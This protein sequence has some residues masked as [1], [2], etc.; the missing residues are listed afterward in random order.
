MHAT[1][2][3]HTAPGTAGSA[4]DYYWLIPKIIAPIF[5]SSPSFKM[6]RFSRRSAHS[7]VSTGKCAKYIFQY[8]QVC[9]LVQQVTLLLMF[10]AVIP[11][12]VAKVDAPTKF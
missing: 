9:R 4:T 2:Q 10:A 12:G 1:Q 8:H 3:N 7:R 11:A 5:T 6:L